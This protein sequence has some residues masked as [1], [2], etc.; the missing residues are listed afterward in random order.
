MD[1][2]TLILLIGVASASRECNIPINVVTLEE[3]SIEINER[4]DCHPDPGA[5]K[6][7]C[8]ARG[9]MWQEAEEQGAPWCYYPPEYGYVMVG[10][11]I[12]TQDG[13]LVHL[14]RTSESSMFGEEAANLWF[15]LEIQKPY[16][17]RIKITDDKP[18]FEVPI[19]IPSDGTRPDDDQIDF[20]INFYNSPVFGFKVTR[21]STNETILDIG[22]PGLVFSDQFIQLPFSISD[23]AA[24]YGWG[25]NEQHSFRHDQNWKTWAIYARDQPPDGSANMYGVH[26]RLTVLDKSGKAFG[27]LF[28]NSAAQELSLTPAPALVYR[29]IGGI[30][31][32]YIFLGPSP[33]EVVQQYTEAIG[34]F[35]LPPYWSLGFHLCRYGYLTLNN[36]VAAV[37]RTR[38]FNIPQDAQWGDIDIMERSL[39]FTVSTQRFSGLPDFVRLL[40]D[41]GIKFVTILDPCIST[42]E[43]NCTYRPFDLGQEL[44]VWIKKPDGGALTGQV[45][46]QDPVYFPDYTNPRTKLWWSTLVNEFHQLLEY[47]GLWIDMN[48]PSNFVTGDMYQGCESK[49]VN[50]PPYMPSIRLDNADHGLAD[51]SLCGDSVHHLGLHYDVHNLFGWSQ[52]QPTLQGVRDATGGRGLVLSRSTFVGS[53]QWVAHWLGDNFSNWPNLRYSIIGMLQFNQFG[54]PMVGAD[55]CGFIGNT[56]EEL[57]LR[58]HQLGAFY[59]FS[60]NHN[61]IGAKAQD[62]GVFGDPTA[63]IIRDALMIRYHLLPYLYTLFYLHTKD[64]NTVARP[65]WHE[66]STDKNTWDVDTQFLWGKA[67]LIS[68]VLEKNATSRELYLPHTSRWF[69]ISKLLSDSTWYEATNGLMTMMTPLDMI[70][71]HVRGGH[72]LPLQQPGLNTQ[73]SRSKQFEILVALNE[74]LSA[75]GEMFYDDGHTLNTLETGDYFLSNFFMRVNVITME[76]VHDGYTGME[77]LV[78]GRVIVLGLADAVTNIIVNG[79]SISDTDWTYSE[80]GLFINNLAIS[81]NDNFEIIIE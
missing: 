7:K 60:R 28:L 51:K 69:T 32:M 12:V 38:E 35:P 66:F 77:T 31:D 45:W 27:I 41:D 76:V 52:S 58:W 49:N 75:E 6:E 44:D 19:T 10:D 54:I 73:I 71:L 56:E 46:P 40:R 74:D 23:S 78:F 72:I 20:L 22:L 2:L 57:C 47:D 53:G 9:C 3:K 64:G 24:V 21:K 17:M 61:T 26:P 5:Y 43:P 80:G 68:P 15:T 13:Y 39:D 8:E 79:I 1:H 25:E 42:G 18:R 14:V 4:I 70:P 30:L 67:L 29:T 55:I 63:S 62:P 48:E 50:Y 37:E 65:L 59:P 34:R 16:R 81:S 36:M 33:E 11:P